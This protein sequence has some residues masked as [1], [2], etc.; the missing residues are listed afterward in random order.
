M[1]T[2]SNDYKGL[3]TCHIYLII[4]MEENLRQIKCVKVS[5][6]LEVSLLSLP[7]VGEM[8]VIELDGKPVAA[9]VG[10]TVLDALEC[11]DGKVTAR[12]GRAPDRASA[13]NVGLDD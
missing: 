7:S 10:E 9:K 11:V 4:D 5:S 13:A 3:F 8:R 2:I 12:R 6:I 1:W